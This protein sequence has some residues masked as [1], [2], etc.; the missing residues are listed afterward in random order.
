MYEVKSDLA[1]NRLTIKIVGTIEEEEVKDYNNAV[2]KNVSSLKRG[3]TALLDLRECGIFTQQMVSLEQFMDTKKIAIE[4]GMIVSAMVVNSGTL[5][6]QIRR[7]FREVG[8][9]D[10]SFDNIAEA[11]K[12]LD[13]Y[14][15]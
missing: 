7:I 9:P 1:K 4:G 13:D 8:S 5:K 10:E 6:M 14:K 11:E 12:F 15:A 2:K 3:F